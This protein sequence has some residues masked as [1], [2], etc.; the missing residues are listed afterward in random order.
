MFF[1]ALIILSHLCYA[2]DDERGYIFYKTAK[3]C[4][5]SEYYDRYTKNCKD[6]EDVW[7]R[8]KYAKNK[9][10]ELLFCYG[11]SK[12]KEPD[13]CF[14]V[15][16]HDTDENDEGEELTIIK[17]S[18]RDVIL[19]PGYMNIVVYNDYIIRHSDCVLYID[20]ENDK[21]KNKGKGKGL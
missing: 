7:V 17:G 18:K 13:D 20:K 2:S 3:Y 6:F 8:Y 12:E 19:G 9:Y 15:D 10:S 21:G 1:I 11:Y 14:V 16:S 5:K 4:E